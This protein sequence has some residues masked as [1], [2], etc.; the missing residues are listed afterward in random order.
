MTLLAVDF[1]LS[2]TNGTY[3]GYIL[4]DDGTISKAG[5]VYAYF[6]TELPAESE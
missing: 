3:N 5:N 2:K 4:N 6:G 1:E